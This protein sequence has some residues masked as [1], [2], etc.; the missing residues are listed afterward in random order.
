M[1]KTLLK[2][3]SIA[4]LLVTFSSYAS[5]LS[6]FKAQGIVGEKN[7][8]YVGL[9]KQDSAAA[10]IVLEINEKRRKRYQQLAQQNNV[11]L[12]SIAKLAAEKAQEKTKAG[13]YIQN[14]AGTW[15]KK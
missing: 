8:G 9:V 5:P 13:Q 10:K 3:L 7:D 12:A 11:P 14:A 4:L 2:A 1:M 15:V 6:D